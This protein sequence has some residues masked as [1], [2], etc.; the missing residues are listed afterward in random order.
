MSCSTTL[1][2]A[3]ALVLAIGCAEGAVAATASKQWTPLGGAEVIDL[4]AG[5]TWKWKNG[6]AYFAPD[7]R[8]KA[9]SRPEESTDRGPRDLGGRR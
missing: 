4:Y 8:F 7:G 3:C 5:K 9:W 6:A 1:T 2:G